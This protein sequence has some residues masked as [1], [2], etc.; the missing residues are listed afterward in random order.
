[1][2]SQYPVTRQRDRLSG[3]SRNQG[4]A[5]RIVRPAAAM[6]QPTRATARVDQH[7]DHRRRPDED[8]EIVG[9]QPSRSGCHE[10]G[11]QTDVAPRAREL[12]D[13]PHRGRSEQPQ[14]RVHPPLR[15]V[16]HAGRRQGEEERRGQHGGSAA[17]G[18]C[19]RRDEGQTGQGGEQREGAKRGIPD[20]PNSSPRA[21][22]EVVQR[23]VRVRQQHGTRHARGSCRRALVLE[24][25]GVVRGRLGGGRLEVVATSGVGFFGSVLEAVTGRHAEREKLVRPETLAIQHPRPY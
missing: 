5:A 18:A 21:E 3:T 25:A 24:V 13:Q 16:V 10:E 6:Q 7:P 19:E 2:E 20:A 15:R 11:G 4:R 9:I 22:E 17:G 14:E 12:E 8:E 1:M 23:G